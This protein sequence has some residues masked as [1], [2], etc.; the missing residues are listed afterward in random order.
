[1]YQTFN[2]GMGL[3]IVCGD[4]DVDKVIEV[5]ARTGFGAAW[6]GTVVDTFK[7]IKITDGVL[8]STE[9]LDVAFSNKT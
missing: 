3:T 1:M 9:S 6:V 2:M 4:E 8:G 5:F 7:G